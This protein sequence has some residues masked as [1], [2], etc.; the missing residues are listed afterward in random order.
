MRCKD[1]FCYDFAPGFAAEWDRGHWQ[2]VADTQAALT[3][4]VAMA[5]VIG[6]HAS[7]QAFMKLSAPNATWNAK[8]Y[9][10]FTPIKV[11]TA[12]YT[13]DGSQLE[14]F[15]KDGPS[16]IDEV[17]VDGCRVDMPN[18]IALGE[19]KVNASCCTLPTASVLPLPQ[20]KPPYQG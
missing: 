7:P 12:D 18:Q 5:V 19:G 20:R 13:P 8:M 4:L 14:A 16:F 11:P 2:A 1:L 3:A 6:N 17:H 10:D 9:E 15:K